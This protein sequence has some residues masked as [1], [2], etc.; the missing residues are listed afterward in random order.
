MGVIPTMMTAPQRVE[1]RY[2][3]QDAHQRTSSAKRH[4]SWVLGPVLMVAQAH[5]GSSYELAGESTTAVACARRNV[6][7]RQRTALAGVVGLLPEALDAASSRLHV[8][9]TSSLY[10]SIET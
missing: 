4:F 8:T 2:H 1:Q 6:F 10:V 5:W 9:L 7:G 3:P